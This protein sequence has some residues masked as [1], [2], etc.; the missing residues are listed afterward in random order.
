MTTAIT[1]KFQY[2]IRRKIKTCLIKKKL[3]FVLILRLMTL[4]STVFKFYPNQL[5]SGFIGQ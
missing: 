4:L 2:K 1:T 3:V 5:L